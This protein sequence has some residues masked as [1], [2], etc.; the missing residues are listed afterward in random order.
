MR[1]LIIIFGE[2]H[3]AYR[4][5]PRL[6]DHC[7]T[8]KGL[9]SL[10]KDKK[11]WLAFMD[12]SKAFNTVNIWIECSVLCRTVVS[13]TKLGVSHKVSVREL[14]IKLYLGPLKVVNV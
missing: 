4:K 9:C 13:K 8:L 12:I 6:E 5:E 14:K 10:R 7:Y 1:T 3:G 11:T 2:L